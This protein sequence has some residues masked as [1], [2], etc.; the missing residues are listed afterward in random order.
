MEDYIGVSRPALIA[1]KKESHLA[2]REHAITAFRSRV[3][4]GQSAITH[5]TDTF[6]KKLWKEGKPAAVGGKE[7]GSR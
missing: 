4:A 2:L 3:H 6:Y 7:R 5:A 1:N